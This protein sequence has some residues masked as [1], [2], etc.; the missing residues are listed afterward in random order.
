MPSRAAMGPRSTISNIWSKALIDMRYN[1]RPGNPLYLLLVRTWHLRDAVT[2]AN[3]P[4]TRMQKLGA[5]GNPSRRPARRGLDD[6]AYI[7]AADN[8]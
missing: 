3:T 4:L 7:F 8:I 1:Y 2:I 6:D 5:A